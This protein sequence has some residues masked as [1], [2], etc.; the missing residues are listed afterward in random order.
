[1]ND[2]GKI[3]SKTLI[4]SGDS[5]FQQIILSSNKFASH[6]KKKKKKKEASNLSLI[7]LS[8]SLFLTLYLSTPYL[9]RMGVFRFASFIPDHELMIPGSKNCDPAS[10]DLSLF[11]FFGGILVFA[12]IGNPETSSDLP[13]VLHN[14]TKLSSQ[15]ARDIL[16]EAVHHAAIFFFYRLS[17]VR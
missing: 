15:G 7:N 3:L 13:K 10:C 5:P 17:D 12:K 8:T 9:V 4:H 16:C 2:M 14:K 6:V 1:M 11:F